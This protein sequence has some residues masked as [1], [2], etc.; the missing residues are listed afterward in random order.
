MK[1]FLPLVEA[2]L[3]F[4]FMVVDQVQAQQKSVCLQVNGERVEVH[5]LGSTW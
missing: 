5:Y 2:V 1:G 3:V 4:A